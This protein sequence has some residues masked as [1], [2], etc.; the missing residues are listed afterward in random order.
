M[1]NAVAP[2]LFEPNTVNAIAAVANVVVAAIALLVAGLSIRLSRRTLRG[3][4]LHNK[5][6]VRPLAYIATGNYE[7]H[8]WVKI[9]NHG[10]GPLILKQV[11]VTGG[12][13]PEKDL[14]SCMPPLPKA[15]SWTD[16]Q[17]PWVGRPIPSGGNL[18]LVELKGDDRD[19]AFVAFRDTCK[20]ALKALTV[21]VRYTD[22]YNDEFIEA[23]KLDWFGQ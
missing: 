6:S 5:L 4:T 16:Y 23:R 20:S 12:A 21:T 8:I 1:P 9:W 13:K 3:Q 2:G 10:T 17:V 7:S 11:A 15:I 18:I 22:I 19:P 14:I